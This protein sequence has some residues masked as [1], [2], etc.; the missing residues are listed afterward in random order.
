MILSLFLKGY[1][2]TPNVQ[3]Q[4]SS[5][6]N[7]RWPRHTTKAFCPDCGVTV[8]TKLETYSTILTILS[9]ILLFL[10]CCLLAF[11]PFCIRACN[12]TVH[13]CSNCGRVLGER[14][15]I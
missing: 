10:V 6:N 3:P 4:A 9:A 12:K 14:E 13:Y 11:L 7:N 15:A 1:A 5:I 8:D 2:V